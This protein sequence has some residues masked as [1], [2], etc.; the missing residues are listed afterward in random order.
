MADDG[1]EGTS[2]GNDGILALVSGCSHGAVV[3]IT[4]RSRVKVT[5]T[6]HT[7]DGLDKAI[8]LAFPTGEADSRFPGTL[9]V[10]QGGK[11]LADLTLGPGTFAPPT[12]IPGL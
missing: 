10:T 7:T 2:V 6:I 9:L 3:Q 1:T 11:T 5:A 12:T 8:E 4:G